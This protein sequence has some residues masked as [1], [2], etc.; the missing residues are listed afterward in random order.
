M[1]FFSF[2]VLGSLTPPPPIE[3]QQPT[4]PTKLE[5]L[6]FMTCKEWGGNG[7][8]GSKSPH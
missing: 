7:K 4:S 5:L 2:L 1:F 6:E 3:E 8:T